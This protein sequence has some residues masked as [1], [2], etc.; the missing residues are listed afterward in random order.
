MKTDTVMRRCAAA[1][2]LLCMTC[3]WST[4]HAITIKVKKGGTA[5]FLHAWNDSGNLLGNFPG[6]QFT[7][8]DADGF[9]TMDVTGDVVSIIFSMGSAGPQTGDYLNISGV[10]G[11]AKFIYDGSTT[12]YGTMPEGVTYQSGKVAYFI[13]PPGWDGNVKSKIKHNGYEEEHT[14]TKIGTDGAGLDVYADLNFT[15]WG[16]TPQY[17]QFYD[18]SNHYCE[19][20]AYSLGGYFDTQ[21]AVA[22]FMD[23]NASDFPDE[24]FRNAIES[25]G[26]TGAFSPNNITH[27][28]V[29]NSEISNL[30][31][32][33]LF[34][35][36]IELNAAGNNLTCSTSDRLKLNL[37][38]NVNLETLNLNGNSGITSVDLAALTGLQHLE[39]NHCAINDDQTF[40][41]QGSHTALTYLD[42]SD[43]PTEK[44]FSWH[45]YLPNLETLKADNANLRAAGFN[46]DVNHFAGMSKLKYLDLGHNPLVTSIYLT[47]APNLETLILNGNTE[48][49][50][51]SNSDKLKGLSS[52]HLKHL[53]FTDVDLATATLVSNLA[54]SHST[55]EYLDLSRA[56]M[57]S[58]S[59][60][61]FTAL[62]TFKAAGNYNLPSGSSHVSMTT[63]TINN[64]PLL[65]SIDVTDNSAL[66]T[67]NLTNI[68]RDNTNCEGLFTGLSTCTALEMINLDGN[69]FTSVPAFGHDT[70]TSIKLNKNALTSI[71][72]SGADP[73]VRFLYAEQNSFPAEYELTAESAGSLHGL[74]LG[75][76]GFTSFTATG[77]ALSALMVGDNAAMT[78]LTLRSNPNLTKTT[79][80]TTMSEGSGLYLLGNTNLVTLDLESPADAPGA[81][82][83]LGASGSLAGLTKVK[84]LKAAYNQFTTFTN[85]TKLNASS[86]YDKEKKK[87]ITVSAVDAHADMPNLEALTGLEWLDLSHNALRDSVHLYKNTL[88]KYLD[89]SHNQ[90]ITHNPD[91]GK[92]NGSFIST[93]TIA[94]EIATG[95]RDHKPYL[96]IA[97]TQS[98]VEPYTGDQNDTIG[99]YN[100]DLKHN[101]QV[102]YID[103]SHT[104][105]E[106]TALRH[107]YTY[108]PRYI[109]IQDCAALKEF[110][111]DY[112]G[113]RAFGVSNNP[114]MERI[115]ARAMRGAD[116]VTMQ[117]SINLHGENCPN[118]HFADFRDSQFDSIGTCLTLALD[119]LLIS[120]NPI[121]YL[122]FCR[123]GTSGGN[124]LQPNANLVY[125][126]AS[127]CTIDKRQS[128][129][130]PN[131]TPIDNVGVDD[132]TR[133]A[134]GLLQVNAFGLPKLKVLKMTGDTELK[135]I[136]AY[137]DDVLP[138]FEGLATCS[139]LETLHAY[140]DPA[141]GPAGLNVDA[142]SH[143]ADLW[144]SNDNLTA[145]GV[146]SN[147]EL[148][149]LRCYG[150]RSL[151]LLDVT[152]NGSL[153][154]LDC[155]TCML[156]DLDVN[157]NHALKYLDCSSDPELDELPVATDH[158]GWNTISDLNFASDVIEEVYANSNDLHCI[159][160][161]TGKT[162]LKALQFRHNHIN[163]IDLT[164]CTALTAAAI[165]DEDNG[166]EITANYA[167]VSRKQG[168]TV[169]NY[170]VYFF[171][172]DAENTGGNNYLGD[173]TSTDVLKRSARP[174]LTDEGMVVD[175]VT[176]WTAG[177]SG[178]VTGRRAINTPGTADVLEPGQVNG[179][180]VVLTPSSGSTGHSEY[181][182]DNGISESTFYLDWSANP[183][184]ISTHIEDSV[185]AA[186]VTSTRYVNV[187]G[188]ESD[189]PFSGVNIVVRTHADGTVTTTKEVH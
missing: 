29:S 112:N 153:E 22:H 100:I 77:T 75:N 92:V 157:S 47:G 178:T 45:Q 38:S 106:Y 128:S 79:A 40:D 87:T 69:H 93:S 145:L 115:S 132:A 76:N 164:G 121:Q 168:N 161:L 25:T 55:L 101:P 113:M 12:A 169:Q 163:G 140:N 176:G 185:V 172:V 59:L 177:S 189:K 71:D 173:E 74:D 56:T 102:E 120:G 60:S 118:L 15:G 139:A 165:E 10:N 41:P 105:I 146:S 116:M 144:V 57:Q 64:S 50:T 150:N 39:M 33:H 142:N 186:D 62:T 160:G 85:A 54:N 16:D 20:M 31:G 24:N 152:A 135:N 23:L 137:D 78:T 66:E 126:D 125:V 97:A 67:L 83:S 3:G 134:S 162:A 159:T 156:Q 2:V 98:N 90:T 182:Y 94:N 143:L 187:A 36:L 46:S 53:E 158:P 107:Y 170:D 37:S 129:V 91:K 183:A 52:L 19:Y 148:K 30:T 26:V 7:E 151:P 127:D 119:T 73:G 167:L 14:M 175:N 28:D 108:N 188:V 124:T 84:T 179:T 13:C 58:P 89:V 180:V 61:G 9:W 17:I 104:G 88:L 81:F 166:R 154:L 8:K 136:Y 35:N 34:T 86:Y 70:Y 11:V 63:L 155:H 123:T 43:N 181:T 6:T 138:G 174:K 68:G 122:D 171:Q 114:N 44:G 111:A 80:V 99:V 42:M 131:G 21:K 149:K 130:Y 18:G 51:A 184:D 49:Q 5:P 96:W 32:I 110:Y 4:A 95:N 1:V 48:L 82:N 27:L 147:L 133:A 109:W 117:G 141:I 103:I 65:S 72:M